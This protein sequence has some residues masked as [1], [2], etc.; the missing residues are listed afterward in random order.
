VIPRGV[1]LSEA[2]SFGQPIMY[3]DKA[4]KGAAAYNDLAKEI[5]DNNK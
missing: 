4:S 2:P 3:F 1:R 5:A